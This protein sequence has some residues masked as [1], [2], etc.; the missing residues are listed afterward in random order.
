MEFQQEFSD[1][2]WDVYLGD[3]LNQSD[4]PEAAAPISPRNGSN[5]EPQKNPNEGIQYTQLSRGPGAY[6]SY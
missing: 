5:K 2:S 1:R 4:L 6:I 3:A